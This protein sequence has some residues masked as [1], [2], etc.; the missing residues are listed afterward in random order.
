MAS[1]HALS[2]SP[3]PSVRAGS[4]QLHSPKRTRGVPGILA[5]HHIFILQAKLSHEDISEM[6]ELA[7]RAGADV[8]SSPNDA[9]VV[10][11]AIAMRRRLERHLDWDLAKQKYL[12]TPDWLRGSVAQGRPLPCADYA[13]CPELKEATERARP[14][15]GPPPPEKSPSKSRSRSPSSPYDPP[16]RAARANLGPPAFLLPPS[17]RPPSV[18]LDHAARLCCS[19]ASPLVCV[20]QPLCAALDVLRRSRALESNERSALSYARAIAS[21]FPRK[22]TARE[23]GEV[24]NLPYV[25]AKISKMIDEYLFHGHIPEVEEARRSERFAALSLFSTIHGIG[26]VTARR[27]YDRGLRSLRDLEAYYEVDMGFKPVENSDSTDMNIRIALELRD[28]LTLTI[29]RKDV[30]TIH[31][32]IVDHLEAVLP[33]CVSTI[34]GRVCVRAPHIY[35]RGKPASNDIDIVFTHPDANSTKDLCTRLVDRLRSAGL[36]T[37]VMHLSG[38]HEQNVLR[39][40]HWDSL[41]KALTVYRTPGDGR[42]RRVDLIF[43]LPETYWT[44]VVGWTG[45]TMFERDLRSAAKAVGLKFDSSGITRRRDSKLIYPRSEKEVFDIIGLPW[46]DPTLRNTDA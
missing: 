34:V 4:P 27:L 42:Y 1:K 26:P 39:T 10:I 5:S 15:S 7:E 25:G 18:Q 35:R 24:Q 13:A 31:A 8:V 20:N 2:R 3:S 44:A 6:F 21:A 19:R 40:A 36:V 33:G 37:H 41:E 9:D 46:V 45:G 17:V 16:P 32:T 22:I 43:A 12:V 23:R 30:E 11:T 28:D 29:P 14:R 38:F